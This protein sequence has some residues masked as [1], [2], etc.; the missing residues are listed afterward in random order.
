MRYVHPVIPVVAPAATARRAVQIRNVILSAHPRGQ[1]MPNPASTPL[2]KFPGHPDWSSPPD[3]DLSSPDMGLGASL[4]GDLDLYLSGSPQAPTPDQL[5]NSQLFQRVLHVAVSGEPEGSR[6]GAAAPAYR[7][8]RF[9]PLLLFVAAREAAAAPKALPPK[10]GGTPAHALLLAITRTLPPPG[11]F[12]FFSAIANQLR[13]VN[14]HTALWLRAILQIFLDAAGPEGGAPHA[15]QAI[16]RVLLE[17]RM[18]DKPRPW[19]VEAA[20][21]EL[22]RGKG[23]MNLLAAPFVAEDESLFTFCERAKRFL[24]GE[25]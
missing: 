10:A 12:A 21:N 5:P 2:A 16:A 13:Y 25:E 1:V 24:G 17:R 23:G 18:V 15:Q 14:A 6:S 22:L 19:G 7:P 3:I 4:A 8:E 11:L 9:T 20:A